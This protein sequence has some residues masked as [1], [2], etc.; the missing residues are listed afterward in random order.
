MVLNVAV[1]DVGHGDCCVVYDDDKTSVIVVDCAHG[2]SLLEFLDARQLNR[3]DL[4]LLTHNDEDHVRGMKE[5]IGE[6]TTACLGIPMRLVNLRGI[7]KRLIDDLLSTAEARGVKV[8]L[9]STD[10]AEIGNRLRQL[11]YAADLLYPDVVDAARFVRTNTSSA[12]LRLQCNETRALLTGDID[13]PGWNTMIVRPE[14]GPKVKAEILKFPHHGG[15]LVSPSDR[16][17]ACGPRA[18]SYAADFL[19]KVSP[20]YTLIST[21]QRRGWPHPDP[22]VMQAIR[23]YAGKVEHRALCTGVTTL[24]EDNPRSLCVQVLQKLPVAHQSAYARRGG[25]PCAGT[26]RVR[27]LPDGEVAVL[28]DQEHRDIVQLYGHPQCEQPQW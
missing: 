22:A 3:I 2:L 23:D 17:G 7:P 9:V 11:P 14:V 15:A 12:V 5:V 25:Y 6:V 20:R 8:A 27:L 4:A 13:A 26:I 24:C 28:P 10:S 18:Y 19:E 1:L 21:G 16:A